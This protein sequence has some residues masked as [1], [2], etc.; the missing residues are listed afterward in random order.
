MGLC[1]YVDLCFHASSLPYLHTFWHAIPT[2]FYFLVRGPIPKS[3]CIVMDFFCCAKLC[4][5]HNLQL[6]CTIQKHC[7]SLFGID[8]K[9][10]APKVIP[11]FTGV[12]AYP[13]HPMP[14]AFDRNKLTLPFHVMGSAS[15]LAIFRFRDRGSPNLYD[16]FGSQFLPVSRQSSE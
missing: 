1:Q 13:C 5:S 2:F 11:F 15:L 8:F 12:T 4:H 14:P 16:T 10:D 9:I 3:T 7:S 6:I